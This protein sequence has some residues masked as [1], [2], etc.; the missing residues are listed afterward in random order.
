MTAIQPSSRPRL[1]LGFDAEDRKALGKMALGAAVI[2]PV[3]AFLLGGI[4]TAPPESLRLLPDIGPLLRAPPMILVHLSVALVALG[5]GIGILAMRKGGRLHKRP[6]RLWAGLMIAAA[7]TGVLVEPTRFTPAHATALIVFAMIPVAIA[8]VRKG[9]LRGHRRT[10]AY[11]L[12]AMVIVAGL[13]VLPGHTL[14][15]VFFQPA[16]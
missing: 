10:I 13:S 2:I 8:K 12:I 15:G 4:G 16:A 7:V 5:G 9:D 1:V 6:G 11:L 3:A 14:H